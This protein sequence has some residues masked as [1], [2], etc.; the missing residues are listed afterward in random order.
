[1]DVFISFVIDFFK[2]I[3]I[4][5]RTSEAYLLT[6]ISLLDSYQESVFNN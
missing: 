4:F 5:Y 2:S 1:M 3:G 6:L